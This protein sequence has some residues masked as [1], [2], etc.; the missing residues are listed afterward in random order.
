MRIGE[1]AERIGVNTKTIR[2]YES[3]GLVP[4]P[5]RTCNGYRIYDRTD[6][7]RIA[8]IKSAQHLGLSLEEIREVMALRQAGRAPCERVR[9]MLRDH[10]RS[11]TERI[12]ELHR[13][14]EELH[15]LDAVIDEIPDDH[16]AVCR[17]IELGA[18]HDEV[19][20][21]SET[22][23]DAGSRARTERARPAQCVEE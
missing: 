15:A 7:V 6:E 8:F 12:A 14:R 3:I 10:I 19:E 11:T 17:I 1:L 18:A 5:P 2:Y 20:V 16:A 23:I 9:T 13:L 21:D 22:K 4:A